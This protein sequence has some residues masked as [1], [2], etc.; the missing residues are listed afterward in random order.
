MALYVEGDANGFK[1]LTERYGQSIFAF[2]MS[3]V[4]DKGTAEDL[5][6]EVF[7]RVVRSASQFKGHASVRTWLYTIARN[8]LVD[9]GRKMSHRRKVSLDEPLGAD[10]EGADTVIST[11]KDH[12][13]LQ[14]EA[15]DMR[16]KILRLE[17]LME[18]MPDEQREVFVLR[19][20]QGL[21]FREIATLLDIPENTVKSRMRYALQFLRA[22]VG[23]AM[24]R[25]T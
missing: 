25:D 22:E 14:D 8:L 23:H 20:R 17:E 15:L 24:E 10:C 4:G 7:M 21:K 2:I 3:R 9:H 19:Q 1:V 13:P 5:V 11:S 12:A 6:Q 18:Q 16:R